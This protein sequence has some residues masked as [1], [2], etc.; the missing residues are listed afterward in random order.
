MVTALLMTSCVPEK[1]SVGK[2][3]ARARAASSLIYGFHS[4]SFA[5]F[6]LSSA[7]KKITQESYEDTCVI[8]VVFFVGSL[9]F[10][11]WQ[12]LRPS[13]LNERCNVSALQSITEIFLDLILPF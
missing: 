1:S 7:I 11:F 5:F 10:V 2:L 4:G 3:A 13:F 12:Y 8:L 9:L 6:F